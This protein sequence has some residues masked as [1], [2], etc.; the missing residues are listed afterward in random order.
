MVA[1]HYTERGAA[2]RLD[3][4]GRALTMAV[5]SAL[6]AP[7]FSDR[8][9]WRWRIVGDRAELAVDHARGTPDEPDEWLIVSCGAALHHARTA[10]AAG[11][12]AAAVE[13][14]PRADG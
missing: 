2:A 12:A 14:T 10:L 7:S 3:E 4:P 13:R 5:M 1:I 9:P 11:G 8:Q 6:E